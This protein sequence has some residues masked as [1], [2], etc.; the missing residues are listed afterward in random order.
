MRTLSLRRA[1][2]RNRAAIPRAGQ[3]TVAARSTSEKKARRARA[4]S[5]MEA[6]FRLS[7]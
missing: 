3:K 6:G 5:G 2:R 7:G 1:I 4:G